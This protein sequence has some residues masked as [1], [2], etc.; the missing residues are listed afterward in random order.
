MR[1]E[2]KRESWDEECT[3]RATWM[4]KFAWTPRLIAWTLWVWMEWYEVRHVY[5][6][7]HQM[8]GV[9]WLRETRLLAP[10]EKGE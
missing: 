10:P 5:G 8:A 7:S 6:G 3:R 9:S 4:R 2:W 1:W